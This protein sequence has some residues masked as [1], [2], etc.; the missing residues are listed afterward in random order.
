MNKREELAIR[1]SRRYR[2]TSP[3]QTG[4]GIDPAIVVQQFAPSIPALYRAAA[5]ILLNRQDS[6]DALQDGL[7]LAFSRLDQFRGQNLISTWLYSIVRNSARMQ[8]RSRN[9]IRLMPLPEHAMDHGAQWT[10]PRPN[11]EEQYV[12]SELSQILAHSL[13]QLPRAY[14]A[15]F[16]L[17]IVNGLPQREVARMLGVSVSVSVI[18]TRLHRAQPLLIRRLRAKVKGPGNARQ[19]LRRSKNVPEASERMCKVKESQDKELL[20]GLQ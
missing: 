15:V 16:R 20:G 14:Q 5:R 9:R 12:R 19:R 10:D 8:M 17:C 13:K 2:Q 1:H 3:A 4:T 7:L 11:P 18:K 6:E